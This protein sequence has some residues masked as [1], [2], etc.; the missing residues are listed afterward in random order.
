MEIITLLKPPRRRDSVGVSPRWSPPMP[1]VSPPSEQLELFRS[2]LVN[3]VDRRHPLVRF[4]GLIYWQ[5]F[6]EAVGPLYRDGVGRPGLPTRL[7][8]GLHLIKHMDGLSD[9][10]VCARFLD[11]PYSISPLTN[12]ARS[13]SDTCGVWEQ[14]SDGAGAA[15]GSTV[16]DAGVVVG[17]A[18]LTGTCV[19]RPAAG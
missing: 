14:V 17:D 4:A 15:T 9:E 13:D 2:A 16:G 1:P 3:L 11:S 10:A 5:R 12:S 7:M 18:T 19:L 6:A 8:A